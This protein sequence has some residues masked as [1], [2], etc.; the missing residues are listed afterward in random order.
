MPQI[1]I[2]PDRV[3]NQIAA[4]EVVERPVAVVKELIENS[5]DA[6]ATRI[7]IDI[8][9]GG[10]NLI[11][12]T[13]NGE[14]M[15]K[16]E[17]LLALER[18]ATSKIREADDLLRISSFGF[19]GEALP[20]IASVCD[21]TLKTRRAE[22][23]AG[24]EILMRQ[25]KLV[26]CRECGS[27]VGTKIEVAHLFNS[28]P[29]R[30]KFLKTD[31]T[32]TAHIVQMV[33][34]FSLAHPNTA[35]FLKVDGREIIST[36]V[37]NSIKDRI[38]EIWGTDIL[39]AT[40]PFERRSGD[41]LFHGRL[42]KP[43]LC[44]SSRH[45][46]LC[47]VNG[48]PVDSRTIQYGVLEACTGFLPKG[49]YPVAFLFLQLDPSAI[50]VN[51]HPAKREVRFRDEP[52]IRRIVVETVMDLLLQRSEAP[53]TDLWQVTRPA[54]DTSSSASNGPL[55]ETGKKNPPTSTPPSP[56]DKPQW[57]PIPPSRSWQP[58][59]E[60]KRPDRPSENNTPPVRPYGKNSAPAQEQGAI[61][62]EWIGYLGETGI[63][64]RSKRG[65]IVLHPR[66]ASERI[67]YEKIRSE[68][69]KGSV[70]RQQ[71]LLPQTFEWE[72]LVAQC[73]E[74]H[75]E[76]FSQHGFDVEP[77]GK[78]FF[79]VSAVPA[80][81]EPSEAEQFLLDA[82]HY[83]R[84]GIVRPENAGPFQDRMAKL[85]SRS[86]YQKGKR[87]TAEEC[88]DLLHKLLRCDVPH[89]CPSGKPT[90]VEY[91]LQELQKRFGRLL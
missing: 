62:W 24:T 88:L 86:A 11:R 35:F 49:R 45:D 25:G 16:D 17:A 87:L 38:S 48:R 76:I 50:D 30:R 4:G 61:I 41:V 2:L 8:Q 71:L 60:T 65:L 46:M 75:L 85:A 22:D 74:E 29:A 73:L 69:K 26:D 83:I 6:G 15:Q 67:H 32:E 27:P 47:L 51:V 63:L 55:R 20:S 54:V 13:D 59:S 10:K 58:S 81:F 3:A 66:A 28:V 19:R 42:G 44:R 64:L 43:P 82:V 12:L 5:L 80:W 89:S 70:D 39:Q 18:H 23:K 14:G 91:E 53:A 68:F 9:R 72:P 77:F 34:M 21:F 36:P 57:K 33:R 56:T 79:R 78:N 31:N 90:Y 52:G 40:L 7:Q 37:C 84:D 1:R